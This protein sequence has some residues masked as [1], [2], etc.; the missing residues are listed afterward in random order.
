MTA[1]QALLDED[2]LAVL[3]EPE[4]GFVSDQAA[5]A[6][7]E[8]RREQLCRQLIEDHRIDMGLARNLSAA[9]VAVPAPDPWPDPRGVVMLAES[10]AARFSLDRSAAMCLAVAV[11]RRLGRQGYRPLALRD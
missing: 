11:T 2:H 7:D 10:A 1:L 6:F 5:G 3:M 8:S 4:D 9:L